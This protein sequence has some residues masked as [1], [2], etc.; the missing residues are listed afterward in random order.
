[1]M[2]IPAVP[3]EQS[4]HFFSASPMTEMTRFLRPL[5]DLSCSFILLYFI[6]NKIFPLHCFLYKF[7]IFLLYSHLISRH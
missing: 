1:M 5:L 4:R 2:V 7:R 3:A 6:S